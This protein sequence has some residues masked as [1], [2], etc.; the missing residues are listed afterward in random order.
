MRSAGGGLKWVINCDFAIA[1]EDTRF[2]FPEA[3]W[4]L[5]VTGGVTHLLPRLVGLQKTREL[6]LFGDRFD[7]DQALDWGLVRKVVPEDDLLATAVSAARRI[8]ALPAAPVRDL[9]RILVRQ[10]GDGLEAA[11]GA[12][13]DATVRGFLDPETA[14]RIAGYV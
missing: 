4:G 6:I 2:F 3:S 9:K 8:A 13:T 1:A 7:A 5:F 11:M 10:S 14:C 12:E